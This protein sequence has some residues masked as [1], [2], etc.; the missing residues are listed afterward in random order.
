L[1]SIGGSSRVERILQSAYDLFNSS[2]GQGDPRMATATEAH[3]GIATEDSVRKAAELVPVLRERSARCEELRQIPPETVQEVIDAGFLRIAQPVPFGGLGLG[4]DTVAEVAMEIGR[5]CPSTAWMV[6]QWSGHNF[7]AGMYTKDA[8]DEH[9]ADGPDALS[10]TA[11][12][13]VKM[14]AELVDGGL[15][16]SSHTEFSRPPTACSSRATPAACTTSTSS[17]AG[18]ATSTWRACSS[19]SRGTSRR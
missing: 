2:Y 11:S 7:I 16:V 9:F 13:V 17:S 19:C 3:A 6:G 5:G 4:V 8:R 1:I 18:P 15:R 10:S 12:A 14:D